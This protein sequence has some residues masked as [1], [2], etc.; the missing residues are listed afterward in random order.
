MIA[1]IGAKGVWQDPCP[2]YP[3]YIVEALHRLGFEGYSGLTQAYLSVF[4][5]SQI[6]TLGTK[7]SASLLT[8]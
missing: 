1:T 8:N 6:F 3:L 2:R 5:S 4:G 7:K